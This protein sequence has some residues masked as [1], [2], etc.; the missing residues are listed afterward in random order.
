VRDARFG[1]GFWPYLLPYFAFLLLSEMAGRLPDSAWLPMLALKPLVPAAL[2]AYFWRAGVYPE[3]R[4]FGSR[5]SRVPL[6]LLVGVLSGFFWMAPYLV[7]PSEV[8]D[9]LG[10]FWPDRSEG[11][12]PARAGADLAPLALALRFTGYALVT[13]VFEE[14]FIR[15]FVMRYAEVFDR[16][17]DFRDV[18]VARFSARALWVSTVFFTLGHVYWEWWVAVPWVLATSLYFRWRGHLGAV[19]AVHASANASILVAA[20]LADGPLWFFV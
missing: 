8:G 9:A 3:L 5:A 17:G 20:W 14:L 7:L 13:P 11:F 15:S 6:D 1:H 2:I 19:I 16:R 12:D 18:P 10:D 4:G